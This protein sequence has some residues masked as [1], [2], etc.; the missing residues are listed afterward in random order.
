MELLV[1]CRAFICNNMYD[2]RTGPG[3]NIPQA[4]P[5]D[6][7]CVSTKQGV[8]FLLPVPTPTL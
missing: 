2:K 7:L 6:K 1:K 3:T 4:L 8:L 5:A